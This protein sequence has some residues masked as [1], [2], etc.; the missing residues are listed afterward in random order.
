MEEISISFENQHDI[1]LNIIYAGSDTLLTTFQKTKKGDI[2]IPGSTI[3]I[4]NLQGQA[5]TNYHI[6]DHIPSFIVRSDNNKQL[7]TYTDL[8]M[9]GVKIA[10]GNKD[11]C[12]IGKV[13]EK[14]ISESKQQESF[15]HNIVVTGSTVNELLSLVTKG[16]VDAALIW[17]DMLHWPEAQGLKLITIPESINSPKKIHLA[18]LA[19]TTAPKQAAIFTEFMKTQGRIIFA[20]HG[21][22]VK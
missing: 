11:M 19:T 18:V 20:K 2:F 6:A 22:R 5:T 7:Q 3:Y 14:I 4:K 13:A 9:K 17:E 15:K 8:T 12:A 16:E 10:I 21:F 1:P